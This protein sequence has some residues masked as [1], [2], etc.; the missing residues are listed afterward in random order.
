VYCINK[1]F[2]SELATKPI[3]TS[4]DWIKPEN[5]DYNRT[6]RSVTADLLCPKCGKEKTFAGKAHSRNDLRMVFQQEAQNVASRFTPAAL[7]DSDSNDEDSVVEAIEDALLEVEDTI[8]AQ[9][10]C[11]TCG[12]LVYIC[13]L[14]EE[15]VHF[16]TQQLYNEIEEYRVQKI[17]EYPNQEASRL[18]VLSKYAQCFPAEYD[19]LSQAERAYNA[20]LGTG[21]IVYIR[22]AYETLLCGII[23]K[24]NIQRPTNFRDTLRKAN[25]TEHIVPAVL[26]DKAYGLFGELSDIVHGDT[27]DSIGMERYKD[28]RDVFL[29]ILDNI[30]EQERM[31]EVAVSIRTD[32]TR[33]GGTTQ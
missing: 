17:G 10:T 30:M 16:N 12:E 28:F 31:A 5:S 25:E 2:L 21:A 6:K 22:K 29:L 24:A 32:S 14:V 15:H 33:R 19:S 3:F 8:T 11:P 4:T 7:F 20:S 18:L 27:D 23:D 13:Y 26:T 9:L 1:D